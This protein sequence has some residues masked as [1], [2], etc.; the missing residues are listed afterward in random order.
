MCYYFHDIIKFEDFILNNILIDEKSH[1]NILIYNISYKNLI[2]LKL[3]RIKFDKTNGF[4]RIYG[5]TR[6]LTLVGFEKNHAIYNS[7]IY[8]FFTIFQN[9]KLILMILYL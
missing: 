3:L 1:K 7:I 4:I 9:S 6:Y 8:I 2:G 5:G